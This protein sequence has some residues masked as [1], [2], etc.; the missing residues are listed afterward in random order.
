MVFIVNTLHA[1]L[2]RCQLRVHTMGRDRQFGGDG[3]GMV[4]GGSS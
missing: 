2:I 4:G 1:K 3:V